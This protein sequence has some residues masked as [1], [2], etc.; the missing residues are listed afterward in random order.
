MATLTQPALI[1]EMLTHVWRH[2]NGPPVARLY[3]YTHPATR[4]ERY[5]AFWEAADDDMSQ[6]PE[7]THPVCLFRDGHVTLD[8][9][10]WKNRYE[11]QEGSHV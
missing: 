6:A 11:A 1:Y 10:L 2:A 9:A 4:Q 7:A 8:G 3:R 5:A